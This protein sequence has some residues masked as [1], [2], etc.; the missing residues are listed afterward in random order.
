MYVGFDFIIYML[1]LAGCLANC[2]LLC[3]FVVLLFQVVI[4]LFAHTYCL[5]VNIVAFV[6]CCVI[7]IS[8]CIALLVSFVLV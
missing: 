6:N 2:K 4:W 5:L 3:L 7:S 8:A 1:R